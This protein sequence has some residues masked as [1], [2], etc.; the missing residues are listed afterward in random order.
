MTTSISN[1]EQLHEAGAINKEQLSKE[2]IQAINNL[3]QKEIGH[4]KTN[5]IQGAE[6]STTAGIIF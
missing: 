2:D 3:S 1:V 4:L 6:V 5:N